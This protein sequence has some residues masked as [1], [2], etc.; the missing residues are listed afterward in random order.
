MLSCTGGL[1]FRRVEASGP[2]AMFRVVV[3]EHVVRYR[4]NV[5]INVD[6]GGDH[7][8]ERQMHRLAIAHYLLAAVTVAVTP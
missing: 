3:D 7:H 4:E 6:C 2:A 8:L 1:T 5:A